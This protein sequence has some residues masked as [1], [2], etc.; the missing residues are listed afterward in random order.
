MTTINDLLAA[1]ER[2]A[3]TTGLGYDGQPRSAAAMA[4]VRSF[5][6]NEER[7]AEVDFVLNEFIAAGNPRCQGPRVV[8]LTAYGT[9]LLDIDYEWHC[10][11]AHYATQVA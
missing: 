6:A 9:G 1:E 2:I 5:Y 10:R 11:P 4:A 8:S 7:M 3:A